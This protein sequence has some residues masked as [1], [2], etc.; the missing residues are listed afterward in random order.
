MADAFDALLLTPPEGA[1]SAS[2]DP[3]DDLF[4]TQPLEMP[5]IQS[6]QAL[7]DS[8]PMAQPMQVIP[9]PGTTADNM[10]PSVPSI[11]V[12]TD[13]DIDNNPYFSPN[14]VP[15]G[16]PLMSPAIPPMPQAPEPPVNNSFFRV[17]QPGTAMGEIQQSA[18]TIGGGAISMAGGAVELAGGLYDKYDKFVGGLMPESLRTDMAPGKAVQEYGED[19]SA[20][21]A[22]MRS[23]GSQ[24]VTP[25]MESLE[26][27]SFREAYSQFPAALRNA[28]EGS[29][30]FI[31]AF[32][33]APS[34]IMA[35]MQIANDAA[36]DKA[37][38]RGDKE[39]S[40]QDY[41]DGINFAIASV[42]S[43][44]AVLNRLETQPG[45]KGTAGNM[46]SEGGQEGFQTLAEEL[47]IR[48]GTPQ[49]TPE[50]LSKVGGG[51]ALGAGM[52][53][54]M[55]I[56]GGLSDEV[57]MM[58]ADKARQQPPI[59]DPATTID[60][61]GGP[62]MPQGPVMPEGVQLGRRIDDAGEEFDRL[63][64]LIDLAPPNVPDKPDDAP[65]P[66]ASGG[67][68]ETVG[69]ETPTGKPLE[70]VPQAQPQPQ[71]PEQQS[72]EEIKRINTTIDTYLDALA[73]AEHLNGKASVIKALQAAGSEI[74]KDA[75]LYEI[76][77][78]LYE[79]PV[80]TPEEV[81]AALPPGYKAEVPVV[82]TD[83]KPPAPAP[84]VARTPAPA[85][86]LAGTDQ[87]VAAKKHILTT[88]A[89]AI[90]VA[91]TEEEV[92]GHDGISIKQKHGEFINIQVPGDGT[93][94]I[95]NTK[96]N[97][98]AKRREYNKIKV[99]E[100]AAPKKMRI[101]TKP[102]TG[103]IIEMLIDGEM[104]NAK[105]LARLQNIDAAAFKKLEIRAEKEA[106][107]RGKVADTTKADNEAKQAE[108]QER[109]AA[110]ERR[111]QSYQKLS[112]RQR[113]MMQ[114][115]EENEESTPGSYVRL[116]GMMATIQSLRKRGMIEKHPSDE[117]KFRVA[118]KASPD[119]KQ[120]EADQNKLEREMTTWM[121]QAGGWAK[122]S[123][124]AH[125]GGHTRATLNKL[126]EKGVLETKV[127]NGVKMYRTAKKKASVTELNDADTTQIPQNSGVEEFDFDTTLDAP[128]FVQEDLTEPDFRDV[129]F[130]NHQASYRNA[131]Y[132][133]GYDHADEAKTL[134][135]EV[136][137]KE[138]RALF[139]HKFGIKVLKPDNKR[140]TITLRKEIDQLMDG[141]VM[142]QLQAHLL[143]LPLKAMSLGNTLIY[144][145]KNKAKFLGQY[146]LGLKAIIL[147]GRSN[148][149]SHEWLH[150]LDNHLFDQFKELGQ[151]TD[152]L[153][154]AIKNAT[155]DTPFEYEP[156]SV[157][158]AMANV[159]NSLFFDKAAIAAEILR[160]DAVIGNTKS[161]KV[162]AEAV[163]EREAIIAGR[164]HKSRHDKFSSTYGKNAR[165]FAKKTQDRNEY[166]ISPHEMMARAFEAYIAHKV[167]VLTGLDKT[168]FI[169]KGDKAYLSDGDVRLKETFPK[170][171]ERLRI[172][173]AFD[174]L[175]KQI[176]RDGLLGEGTTAEEPDLGTHKYEDDYG[177]KMA[178]KLLREAP[179]GMKGFIKMTQ[180]NFQTEYAKMRQLWERTPG[181]PDFWSMENFWRKARVLED[182]NGMLLSNVGTNLERIGRNVARNNDGDR[183]ISLDKM[184][185]SL[186]DTSG[187]GEYRSQET[188][189]MAVSR[190]VRFL[191]QLLANI[192]SK[193]KL[194]KISKE[195]HKLLRRL[196]TSEMGS[197]L[198]K[199]AK[200][201]GKQN[202]ID[203]AVDLHD[204]TDNIW[205][206]LGDQG[207]EIGYAKN[208]YLPR[209]LIKSTVL[210]M[211]DDFVRDATK[212][213]NV[214][215][216]EA[217]NNGN[218]VTEVVGLAQEI[219]ALIKQENKRMKRDPEY[220]A[221][222]GI[223]YMTKETSVT[224][225]KWVKLTYA[226]HALHKQIENAPPEELPKLAKQLA[227]AEASKEKLEK[228]Q[229]MIDATADVKAVWSSNAAEAWYA[230]ISSIR[231][232]LN[233][234][235]MPSADFMKGRKLPKAADDI[236]IKYYHPN[237]TDAIM[238]YI[239]SA[240]YK[241]E[242]A[243]RF[244]PDGSK[245]D[246]WFNNLSKEGVT[247]AEQ[248]DIAKLL[249]AAVG[250]TS[251]LS[252]KWV[253]RAAAS[254]IDL[255]MTAGVLTILTK[256]LWT[257]IPEPALAVVRLGSPMVAMRAY[258][259]QM[260]ALLNVVPGVNIKAVE[261]RNLRAQSYGITMDGAGEA[262]LMSRWG[263]DD[264]FNIRGGAIV[265]SMFRKTGLTG[266]TN[267][268]RVSIMAAGIPTLQKMAR[269]IQAGKFKNINEAVFKEL[270]VAPGKT[271]EGF[272]EYLASHKGMPPIEDRSTHAGRLLATVANTMAMQGIQDPTT[273]DAPV[274]ASNI[275]IRPVFA[276]Q[277]FL[278]AAYRHVTK[279]VIYKLEAAIKG[280]MRSGVEITVA[281]RAMLTAQ[282]TIM[283]G[284]YLVIVGM[285]QM[286]KDFIWQD[287]DR[288]EERYFDDEGNFS[289]GK[290]MARALTYGGMMGAA[291]PLYNAFTGVKYGRDMS[292]LMVGA[293]GSTF[294]H[295]FETV[296]KGMPWAENNSPNT[297]TQEWQAARSFGHGVLA[298]GAVFFLSWMPGGGHVSGV[299]MQWLGSGKSTAWFA[300]QW[301]GEKDSK[302]KGGNKAARKPQTFKH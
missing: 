44:R 266:I 58:Q 86:V 158:E 23:Q 159:L 170:D 154:K 206:Y 281:E 8:D 38:A 19:V 300:N 49:N 229:E 239:R 70:Q 29:A 1:A 193:H 167:K 54:G 259:Y 73:G 149:F 301:V 121:R 33:S 224:L 180:E 34:V 7:I 128:E 88:L 157:E 129:S 251:S 163:A 169:T 233:D 268:Q 258:G 109:I 17:R 151:Q 197:T 45:L 176:E 187:T 213:Y 280:K 199:Q 108:T 99:R 77:Q 209:I 285:A 48:P 115:L 217:T 235:T 204:L 267:A 22:D 15:E 245:L 249:D 271:M 183:S 296:M 133:L 186:V 202:L 76:A 174:K 2:A 190:R 203:A 302:K 52:G 264:D 254:M 260:Q 279:N 255:G 50:F 295:D 139:L 4:Q 262:L 135:P 263:M 240:A 256:V 65:P 288:F 137:V 102:S 282:A 82:K 36:K 177:V 140:D 270:G 232:G 24:G 150:A 141:L 238:D 237:A 59:A 41:V 116:T 220:T 80:M 132:Q 155:R 269:Q 274:L 222:G 168:P 40:M 120:A 6:E 107:R 145:P 226:I 127:I 18:N 124:V 276:V 292:N 299:A 162:R 13:V 272:V 37:V 293:Y 91:P 68:V 81:K 242:Y 294:W 252:R 11:P 173:D 119:E 14:P 273:V 106:K 134:T 113:T 21:G 275:L 194:G 103:G 83:T 178:Q 195:D 175:F 53:A 123:E 26:A 208:G 25:F 153:S 211:P 89:G 228:S 30:A 257:A 215:F 118:V 214:A 192:E 248:D 3:F 230:N 35:G 42:L 205:Y 31:A 110:K 64:E 253:P 184:I 246:T 284:S 277:R 72:P 223:H 231:R 144:V 207:L 74:S 100:T 250:L 96:E 5:L 138:L 182:M 66:A 51:T 75:M 147:P 104:A 243:R 57:K 117:F 188:Y 9:S 227:V 210:R 278:F 200:A 56:P 85:R 111:R 297:N 28:S 181:A 298:P 10:P 32:A 69:V 61:F 79:Y 90:R 287:K 189:P 152:L 165:R 39:P 46:V 166:W 289:F 221:K 105:E 142:L 198:V 218:N 283:T 71:A 160:L 290:M 63:L 12:P 43:E 114:Q 16:A 234:A 122:A 136:L 286:L 241:G 146:N 172:F 185:D 84:I 156:D 171:E 27:G 247:K 98:E 179:R 97:L 261:E 60:M 225:N 20:I 216:N 191:G 78:E 62:R 93:L 219:V 161:E 291:D 201:D 47:T 130:S 148:S 126:A 244:G 265:T 236:L 101:I 55:S 87:A 196:M 131:L 143:G 95:L 164:S 112:A 125:L 67:A 94:K 92:N 212:V